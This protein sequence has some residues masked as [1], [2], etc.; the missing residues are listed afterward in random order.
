MIVEPLIILSK[1]FFLYIY[2]ALPNILLKYFFILYS[3]TSDFF[4]KNIYN[5]NIINK[6]V[7]DRR[8]KLE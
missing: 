4:L 7:I 2:N 8:F 1:V 6:Y 3:N 5:E